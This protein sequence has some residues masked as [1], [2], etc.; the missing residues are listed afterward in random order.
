MKKYSRKQKFF[1]FL[2]SAAIGLG[3]YFAAYSI[4]EAQMTE[5]QRKQTVDFTANTGATKFKAQLDA[6][7]VGGLVFCASAIIN[8]VLKK[9]SEKQ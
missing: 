6:M 1:L 9:I 4:N 5:W 2:V 8:V 7:S 3:A